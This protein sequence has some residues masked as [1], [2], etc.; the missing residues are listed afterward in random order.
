MTEEDWVELMA[1]RI[2]AAPMFQNSG[3][4]IKTGFRLAYG[5]EISA[6]KQGDENAP[7]SKTTYFE[8]DSLSLNEKR[9]I[10]GNH[11][12]SSKQRLR[13]SQLTMQLPTVLRRQ[14]IAPSTLICA[15]A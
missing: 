9:T 12:R 5:F 7:V 15:M 4:E 8:T 2:R 14:H 10:A 6:H 1:K 13:V 3:L 11:V